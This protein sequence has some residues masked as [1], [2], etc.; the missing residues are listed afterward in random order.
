[1]KALETEISL[2]RGPVGELGMGSFTGDF[3]RRMK[4]GSGKG[5]SLSV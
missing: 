2:Y 1:L 3:E 4:E 5:A